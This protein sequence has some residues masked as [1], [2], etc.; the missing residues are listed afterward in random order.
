MTKYVLRLEAI[1]QKP[2]PVA[3]KSYSKVSV[4]Q[5]KEYKLQ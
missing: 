3:K 4:K 2:K 5:T 1:F